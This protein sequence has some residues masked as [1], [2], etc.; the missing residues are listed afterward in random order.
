M[1]IVK[2]C[3]MMVKRDSEGEGDWRARLKS[4]MRGRERGRWEGVAE[5][6]V[7]VP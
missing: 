3:E 6:K 1:D 4:E 7:Y 2:V 5:I